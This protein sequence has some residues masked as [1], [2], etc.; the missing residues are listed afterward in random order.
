MS[1]VPPEGYF[2][3]IERTEHTV[4]R[5]HYIINFGIESRAGGM[6]YTLINERATLLNLCKMT[7]G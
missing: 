4:T 6:E 7:N 3:H 1:L 5:V 2:S